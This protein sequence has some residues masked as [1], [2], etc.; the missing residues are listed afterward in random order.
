[1]CKPVY[2]LF[3]LSMKKGA[4]KLAKIIAEHRKILATSG[5]AKYLRE[6]GI[7]V[8]NLSEI[9]GIEESKTLKTLH[10]KVFEMINT[11]EIDIVVVNLYPFKEKPCVDNIDIGGVTLLRAAAKNFE[12]VLAV[13]KPDQ[14]SEVVACFPDIERLRKKFACTAFRVTSEYDRAIGE[15]ICAGW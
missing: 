3:S 1:M 14:Y 9:T 7:D 5:T 11:G 10:P 8:I 6:R 13:C 2:A 15:W 12:R 4:E